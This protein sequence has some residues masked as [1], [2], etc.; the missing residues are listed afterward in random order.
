MSRVPRSRRIYVTKL[1]SNT[2]AT[3]VNMFKRKEQDRD[4]C[5]R[6][7]HE[8]GDQWHVL[9]CK[10]EGAQATWDVALE[11]LHTSII[12]LGCPPDLPDAILISLNLWRNNQNHPPNSNFQQMG[13]VQNAHAEI[14]VVL[15]VV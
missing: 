2:A 14:C 13:L 4:H 10:D 8:H 1:A 5:P 12:Q 15:A 7:K 3:G 11:K 9:R 6:C